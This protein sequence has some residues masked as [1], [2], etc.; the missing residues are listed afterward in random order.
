MKYYTGLDVAM[1]ETFVC[2][3]DEEG[4]KIYETKAQ[5]TPAAIFKS[6]EKSGIQSEKV[7]IE[8]GSLT[9]FLIKGLQN[10]G[11]PAVC[12]D[13][14]KMSAILS[15]TI[16]KTDKNDAR[17]IADAIRCNHYK[18][19]YVK[20]DADA[21]VEILLKSRKTLV[22][23]SGILKNAIRGFLKTYGVLLGDLQPENFT[24][25]VREKFQNIPQEA[26]DGIK[27]LLK[28]FET[29]SS[30]IDIIDQKIKI[31]TAENKRR[32]DSTLLE[33]QFPW[34]KYLNV[35]MLI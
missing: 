4:K 6:L 19:V 18:E 5:S 15:V 27:S 10:L 2:I 25:K 12:I 24:I 9:R 34:V 33:R 16:N 30:E 32:P 14:R 17:G 21:S 11:V 20:S 3:V 13:S 35:E 23:L 31:L 28:S 29:N 8:T 26:G 1:K 7:G 22:H